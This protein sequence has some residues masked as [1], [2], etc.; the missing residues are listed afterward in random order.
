MGQAGKEMIKNLLSKH[1]VIFLDT[2]V[3]IYHFEG[4]P[5]YVGLTKEIFRHVEKGA[6]NGLTSVISI[7]EILARPYALKNERAIQ[8][9]HI[10]L[11]NFPNLKILDINYDTS[12]IAASLSA[13]YNLDLPD[14]LQIASAL[15][16]YAD[17][18]FTNDKDLE[19][20]EEIKVVILEDLLR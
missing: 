14:S 13:K 15:S 19:K 4:H 9:Y 20:I 16:N 3:F 12:D 1:P 6:N 10:N 5:D 17:I 2:M 8:D 18:F 11:R 7:T